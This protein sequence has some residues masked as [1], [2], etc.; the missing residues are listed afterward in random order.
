MC[1]RVLFLAI[2]WVVSMA[3]LATFGNTGFT[4]GPTLIAPCS[5]PGGGTISGYASD[6][7]WP[8]VVEVF[9][10]N[11]NPLPGSPDTSSVGEINA[12]SFQAPVVGPLRIRAKDDL[13]H[14][15]EKLVSVQ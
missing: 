4:S 5:V 13:G 8:V 10:A 12:F 3:S 1:R 2:A 14:V 7:D 6:A 15:T 11:D 9:D